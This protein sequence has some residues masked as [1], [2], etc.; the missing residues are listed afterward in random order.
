LRFVGFS[1]ELARLDH[2]GYFLEPEGWS[3]EVARGAVYQLPSRDGR[4]VYVEAVRLGSEGKRG[5]S[6]QCGRDGAAIVYLGERHLGERGGDEYARSRDSNESAVREAAR[7]ADSEAEILAERE[8]DYQ[9]A[10]SAGQR[11]A[12]LEKEAKADKA[13]ARELMAE[14]RTLRRSL[15]PGTAPKACAALRAVIR[16][17]LE[18]MAEKLKEAAELRGQWASEEAYQEGL[19]NVA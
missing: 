2:T 17:G 4:P 8:R 9:E 7:G 10:F 3:G 12:E 16:E 1:D 15:D 19:G 13:K 18:T 14:L 11:T 5:W 6:E